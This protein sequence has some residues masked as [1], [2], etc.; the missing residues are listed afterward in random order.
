[1]LLYLFVVCIVVVIESLLI[2]RFQLNIMLDLTV[3]VVAYRAEI[4]F[5][6]LISEMIFLLV[7]LKHI[8][9]Q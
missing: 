8:V 1:M 9:Y 2:Y 7:L 5:L 6:C 4:Y 3:H